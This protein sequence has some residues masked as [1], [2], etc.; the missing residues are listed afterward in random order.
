MHPGGLADTIP[1]PGSGASRW[2]RVP[3]AAPGRRAPA[4]SPAPGAVRLVVPPGIAS[5]DVGRPASHELLRAAPGQTVPR[6]WPAATPP[7][8]L[9]AP[10]QCFTKVWLSS[11]CCTGAQLQSTR[12]SSERDTLGQA[13][14][15]T[16]SSWGFGRRSA[17]TSATSAD[18][19][20]SARSSSSAVWS[21]TT[22][23]R[24]AGHSA[25]TSACARPRARRER[26]TGSA[27][28]RLARRRSWPC[29][30][31]GASRGGDCRWPIVPLAGE[32]RPFWY[33]A[34]LKDVSSESLLERGAWGQAGESRR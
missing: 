13:L 19:K 23:P 10:R 28:R 12:T 14:A 25:S 1:R 8:S 32:Q 16:D 11:V 31:E 30:H 24:C 22:R 18:A 21:V 3:E 7:E 17:S 29:A 6:W 15:S 27:A 2:P 5:L 26:R 4:A 34:L 33:E 20:I 9:S